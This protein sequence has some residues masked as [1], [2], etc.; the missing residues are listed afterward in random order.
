M[1]SAPTIARETGG[2]ADATP[3][4]RA[5]DLRPL[6]WIFCAA[7]IISL[8]V[9]FVRV[10]RMS[11]AYDAFGWLVWAHQALN[12][13]L[14]LNSAPS[15]K[16]L[17]FLFTL[18][19]SLL[20][21]QTAYWLWCYT[22]A[23]AAFAAP[24]FGG[25]CA[26]WLVRTP[27]T[28]RWPA[29]VAAVAAGA[30]VLGILGYWHFILIGYADPLM[31]ALTLAA[32]DFHLCGRRRA[33]WA[34]VVLV[35]LGRPEMWVVGLL[36]AAWTWRTV[37]AM[38]RYLLAGIIVQPLLWVGVSRLASNFWLVSS[39]IDKLSTAGFYVQGSRV[40]AVLDGFFSLYEL[41]VQIAAA[42]VLVL[43]LVRRDRRALGLFAAAAAWL[44]TDVALAIHGELP[45]P[46]YMFEAAAVE[47]TLIGAG[48]GWILGSRPRPA[49][50]R[51]IGVAAAVALVAVMVPNIR[52]RGRLVHNGIRLG[53]TWTKVIRRLD[54]VVAH[55][56][57]TRGI[58]ACGTAVTSVPFQ[59]ILAWQLGLNV[60]EVNWVPDRWIASGK[61]GVVFTNYYAGWQVRVYHPMRSDCDR[62]VRDTPSN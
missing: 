8:G 46:R 29:L 57:G 6:G 48:V 30:G 25:R 20:G 27:G 22:A 26:Y 47:V 3:P 49:V 39:H 17:P 53:R 52:Y 23:S 12:G 11:P 19:Y 42:C 60:R 4:S 31:V 35:A 21:K 45:V 9:V 51:W 62:L 13:T 61:P 41:P 55:E 18:P 54:L 32:V 58:L 36:Y 40:S 59:S 33:A 1:T 37:P 44:L 24:V 43:A 34:M 56:G 5:R 10:T 7:L 50:L 28:R 16:P 38:R 2:A 15:W 14:N